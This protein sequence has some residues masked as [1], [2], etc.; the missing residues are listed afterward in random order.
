MPPSRKN[1]RKVS[2]KASRKASR[3]DSRKASR[4]DSR[5]ASRKDG[6]KSGR[7]DGRKASR[8]CYTRKNRSARK[9]AGGANESL[10]QGAEFLSRHTNQH[11][12]AL[13]T[14]APVGYTGMLPTELRMVARVGGLDGFVADAATQRDPD[15]LPLA[16]PAQKGGR[17]SSKKSKAAKSK[18]AK[19]KAAKSKAAKSSKKSK[20]AK[21]S[22]KSKAAKSAKKSSKKSKKQAG[23]FRSIEGAP[24]GQSPMLLSASQAAKAG[25]ADFSN[26][27]LKH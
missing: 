9:Q 12:G 11:G 5:K 17:R 3:K 4:K 20:A 19:S 24:Y 22:K 10:A 27:L 7:K 6:R 15:Q 18:A 1:T 2:R 25:T 13:L 14:G 16:V 8:R 23:G 21:S 26:P